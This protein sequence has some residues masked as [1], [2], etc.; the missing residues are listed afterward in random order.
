MDEL[1]EGRQDLADAWRVD[2]HR[3]RDPG[4]HGDARGHRNAW[5]DEGLELAEHLAAADL[6]GADLR[7]LLGARLAAGRLE[8]EDDERHLVQRR[9][10]LVEAELHGRPARHHLG[11]AQLRPRVVE[12]P[13]AQVLSHGR[14]VIG[15][16]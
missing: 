13:G 2:D 9:P 3:R 11:S 6:D 5:V 4:E 14:D 8:V 7:D 15:T 1:P 16:R 12:G 10:E